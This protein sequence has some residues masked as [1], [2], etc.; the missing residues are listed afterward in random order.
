MGWWTAWS[1]CWIIICVP[2]LRDALEIDMIG[3]VKCWNE[4]CGAFFIGTARAKY[5]S[6]RCKKAYQRAKKKVESNGEEVEQGGLG[7]KG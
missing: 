6:E 7:A 2:I 1:V 5:C 4:Q 3:K